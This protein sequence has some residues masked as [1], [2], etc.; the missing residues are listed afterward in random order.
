[1]DTYAQ[2]GI[3]SLA[4]FEGDFLGNPQID[5][6][7]AVGDQGVQAGAAPNHVPVCISGATGCVPWNVW[8][9]GG[10]GGAVT[11]DQLNYLL[12]PATYSGTST[13]YLWDGAVTGDLGKY[14]L[15]L[16]TANSGI[17]IAVGAEYR[18]EK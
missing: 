5:N 14:G 13:E 4:D 9:P 8:H 1:Y 16:P 15:K 2:L 10:P 18:Q 3:S 12:T 17:N 11:Q 7:L 6:A